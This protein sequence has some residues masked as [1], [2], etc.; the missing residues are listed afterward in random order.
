MN[1]WENTL[2]AP[3]GISSG[4][5]T[6]DKKVKPKKGTTIPSGSYQAELDKILE[7]FSNGKITMKQYMQKKADLE[8][9]YPDVKKSLSQEF[10]WKEEWILMKAPRMVL[11]AME[12]RPK[13]YMYNLNK[14]EKALKRHLDMDKEVIGEALKLLKELK[15]MK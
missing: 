15:E 13:N 7:D 2:K 8:A 11:D 5:P 3:K 4:G 6:K 10:L 9:K 14:I 1:N 12:D